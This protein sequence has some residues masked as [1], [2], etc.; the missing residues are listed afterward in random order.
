LSPT[1]HLTIHPHKSRTTFLITRSSATILY[2]D[3][4]TTPWNARALPNF[5]GAIQGWLPRQLR[6]AL[7]VDER[8]NSSVTNFYLNSLSAFAEDVVL[9]DRRDQRGDR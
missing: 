1:P 3:L 2:A 6:A 8:A 4:P 5:I 7:V 9:V